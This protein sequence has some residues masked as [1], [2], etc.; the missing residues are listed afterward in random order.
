MSSFAYRIPIL[1]SVL[2]MSEFVYDSNRFVTSS[3]KM[4][5]GAAVWKGCVSLRVGR[6][7]G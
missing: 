7:G 1:L 5:K 2:V 4:T 3:V 6:T